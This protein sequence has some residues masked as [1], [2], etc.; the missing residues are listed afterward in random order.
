MKN[1]SKCN[2]AGCTVLQS[3]PSS[4]YNIDL[5]AA[6]VVSHVIGGLQYTIR[7]ICSVKLQDSLV[8]CTVCCKQTSRILIHH[9]VVDIF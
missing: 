2:N 5:T 1:L 7:L 6:A 8:A 9:L 4:R 3:N